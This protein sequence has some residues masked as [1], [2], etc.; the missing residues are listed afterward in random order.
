MTE[1][2]VLRLCNWVRNQQ[3]FWRWAQIKPWLPIGLQ[4]P[5]FIL[6]RRFES[7]Q[8]SE[9]LDVSF[10][11]IQ[12]RPAAETEALLVAG[13]VPLAMTSYDTFIS[14]RSKGDRNDRD[15]EFSLLAARQSRIDRTL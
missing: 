3:A 2:P 10:Y 6:P 5:R 12:R 7:R 8:P 11:D 13:A 1:Q 15:I 9:A 4:H 14:L